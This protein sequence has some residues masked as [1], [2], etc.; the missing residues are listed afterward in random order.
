[1]M[2]N[3]FHVI[4]SNFQLYL[5]PLLNYILMIF[6]K[7]QVCNQ[8]QKLIISPEPDDDEIK[9]SNGDIEFVM[10]RLGFTNDHSE[11]EG[12]DVFGEKELTKLFE[13]KEPSLEEVKQA[14]DVFDVNKDGFIDETELQRVLCRLGLI[15][16]SDQN[17]H[18]IEMI[19]AVDAN[20]DA[21]IDF[22]EFVTFMDKCFC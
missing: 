13:E 21:R 12:D 20:G 16:S 19:R 8:K 11:F 18:V 1:M 17:S 15:S 3:A 14:F 4:S 22:D 7:Q 6:T 5:Q 2:S 10:G 9:L